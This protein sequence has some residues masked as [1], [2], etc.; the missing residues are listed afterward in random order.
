MYNK[1]VTLGSIIN[2]WVGEDVQLK[3]QG[4]RMVVVDNKQYKNKKLDSLV[5]HGVGLFSKMAQGN[6]Y[7]NVRAQK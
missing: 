3:V 6:L 4:L 2:S 7:N 1:R 5:S